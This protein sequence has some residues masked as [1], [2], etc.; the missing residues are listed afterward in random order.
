MY[1]TATHAK[2]GT[3]V[4]AEAK[5]TED[6]LGLAGG[7]MDLTKFGSMMPHKATSGLPHGQNSKYE[8]FRN[9]GP[10]PDGTYYVNLFDVKTE[11]YQRKDKDGGTVT[12]M[13][14][15]WGLQTVPH[16]VTV[17]GKQQDVWGP[18]GFANWDRIGYS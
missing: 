8:R 9:L 16:T 11:V 7:E 18:P 6:L 15:A 4:E 10:V 1:V 17:D 5:A 12:D 3:T 13:K 2:R 14:P